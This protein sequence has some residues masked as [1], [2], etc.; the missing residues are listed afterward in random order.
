MSANVETMFYVRKTPWHGLGTKVMSA[1]DSEEALIAAGLNWNVIQEPIYTAENETIKG[2]KANVRDSDRKVLGVVTDRYKVVQNY[3]AFSFTDELLGQGVRYETAGSL[4]EGKKVWL[5]AH[6]PHEYIISG[7]RISP[8]LLF[9]NTHDGS[10]AIKVALT[11]IRVVCNNTLNLALRTAERSW[12]MIHTGDIKSKMKEASDTLFKAE[13]YMDEL[14]KEF[15]KLRMHKLT[16]QE[17]MD[18][19]EV[20]LPVEDGSTP[21]QIRNMKRLQEDMKMRYFDAPDLKGVGK[22]AYRFINAVSDFAT[23]AKPL[24]KT[25]N[26]QENLFARTAEG[27]PLIDK[28]YQMVS[29]A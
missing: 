24:R 6:M 9:S 26:Y 10:G 12:S 20:L 21:Q 4:Q 2:Y 8:Y 22:N 28:A 19:I 1:P 29:A 17:V 23:H 14:G 3:E 11:P 16:D 18:Y 13:R 25:A 27:N 5:L 7:E 15:E